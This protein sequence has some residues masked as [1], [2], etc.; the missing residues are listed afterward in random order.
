[1]TEKPDRLNSLEREIAALMP[2]ESFL[3]I[4]NRLKQL[5]KEEEQKLAFL[6]ELQKSY[7]QAG[8]DEERDK[9]K[10]MVGKIRELSKIA[11]EEIK[12]LQREIQNFM[13]IERAREF[14][15]IY[16]ELTEESA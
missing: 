11:R 8:S 3:Q 6:S 4:H 2:M 5:R 10:E 16:V 12:T 13:P 7:I 14:Y 1:M 15:K 9:V